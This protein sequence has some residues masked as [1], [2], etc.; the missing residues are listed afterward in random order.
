MTRL[1]ARIVDFA[2]NNGQ[3]VRELTRRR[4]V[5]PTRWSQLFGHLA[6]FSFVVLLLSGVLLSLWFEP[7]MRQVVYDGGYAPLRGVPMS[8]AY[9]S[10]LDIS[11]EVRGGLLVRQIHQWASL[12]FVA[13]LSAHLLRLFVTGAFRGWRRLSWLFVLTMLVLG[14]VEAYLGHLLPDDLLSGTSL[15]VTEGYLLGI[16]VVGTALAWLVYGGEFPGDDIIPIL[17][18]VHVFVLPIVVIGAFVGYLLTTN[19]RARPAARSTATVAGDPVMRRHA[20]RMGGLALLVFG[21]IVV[22]AATIQ[23]N[24]VWLWGPADPAVATAGSQPPWYVGFLD[25]AVRLMP[26]WD[27]H[28]F[29]HELTLSVIVPVVILPGVVLGTLALYPWFEQYATR[30]RRHPDILDRPRN[31]PVRT[32]LAAA[33]VAFYVVLLIAGG[34]DIVARTLHLSVNAA[35]R[36]LQVCVLV[37]PPLAFWI[38]KRICLGLQ[39]RDHDEV[40]HGRET[41][42]IT[43]TPAGGFTESHKG[44]SPSAVEVRTAHP[45]WTPIDRGAPTDAN[46]VPNPSYQADRH[47][48]LLS[49]FYFSD[50][51]RKPTEPDREGPRIRPKQSV[52][53]GRSGRPVRHRHD[54]RR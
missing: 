22:M 19:R 24:P 14:I 28:V 12:V 7:S 46:G 34:N 10:T 23:V 20:A 33:F 9:A 26:A 38:T 5:F 43:A 8:E 11:F 45:D 21:V 41:G 3:V 13:A 49:R 42:I 2:D 50:V 44:L 29:G 17:N 48:A 53:P 25:G 27:P 37:V 51:V 47:R 54:A 6:V 1:A 32:G 40:V 39:L 35:T 36:F 4:L 31:M 52:G 16:P 15:R 18:A 30:D